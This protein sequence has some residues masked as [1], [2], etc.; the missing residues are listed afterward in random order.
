MCL[1]PVSHLVRKRVPNEK[2]YE[3]LTNYSGIR[4]VAT[5]SS[6]LSASIDYF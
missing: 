4:V 1:C 6:N 3:K 5:R 2:Q